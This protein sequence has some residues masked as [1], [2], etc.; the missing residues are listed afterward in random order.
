LGRGIG[1]RENREMAFR[2]Y[3][4]MGGR[5]VHGILKRLR[6]EHGIGISAHT[7]YAWKREGDW[8][9]RLE[10]QDPSFEERTLVR[11]MGLIEVLERR[12]AKGQKINPADIYAYTG[13]VNTFFRHSRRMRGALRYDPARWKQMAEEILEADYGIRASLPDGEG[14]QNPDGK[15]L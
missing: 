11:M 9:K 4:Q 12:I 5:D 3:A 13:L 14:M 7:Y 1:T 15:R 6:E 8:E 10:G 2:V